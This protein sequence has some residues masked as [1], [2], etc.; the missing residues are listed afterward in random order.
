MVEFSKKK[1]VGV[2]M[3][4]WQ[5]RHKEEFPEGAKEL[6]TALATQHHTREL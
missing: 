5:F 1:N 6:F 4:G 3:G 2:G